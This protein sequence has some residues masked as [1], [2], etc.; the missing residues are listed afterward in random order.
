MFCRSLNDTT[1]IKNVFRKPKQTHTNILQKKKTA[2]KAV[3]SDLNAVNVQLHQTDKENRTDVKKSGVFAP[4]FCLVVRRRSKLFD[5]LFKMRDN[6][7]IDWQIFKRSN[8]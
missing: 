3:L 7:L 5:T 2:F 4:L 6:C 1:K 8:L